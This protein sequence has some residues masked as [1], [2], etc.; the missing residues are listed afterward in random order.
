MIKEQAFPGKFISA[1]DLDKTYVLTIKSVI[2]DLVDEKADEH[3]PVMY[4]TN[5]PKGVVLNVTRWNCAEEFLGA[6]TDTWI[7]HQ[8]E[9]FRST[10]NFAGKVVACVA[11]RQ[12][13]VRAPVG[14]AQAPTAPTQQKIDPINP[15]LPPNDS[16]TDGGIDLDDDI[17]F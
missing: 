13:Q 9:V 1:A 6:D 16:Q 8:I 4:F 12:P 17:P 5:T 11:I 7:G 3:K 10:T 2:M 14:L 15:V